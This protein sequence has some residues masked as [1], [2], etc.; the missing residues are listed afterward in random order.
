MK[1]KIKR[2]YK[3]LKIPLKN[4]PTNPTT[5]LIVTKMMIRANGKDFDHY[6]EYVQISNILH[7]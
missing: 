2:H 3:T 4:V 1:K 7:V 6:H 5:V